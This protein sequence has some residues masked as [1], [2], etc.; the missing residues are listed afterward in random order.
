MTEQEE[1]VGGF[2]NDAD[3]LFLS[4]GTGTHHAAALPPTS[5]TMTRADPRDA[6]FDTLRPKIK[7]TT[8]KIRAAS[9]GPSSSPSSL[10]SSYVSPLLPS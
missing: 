8:S 6:I 4:S 3:A 2:G 5:D 10:P 1:G 9:S 7:K